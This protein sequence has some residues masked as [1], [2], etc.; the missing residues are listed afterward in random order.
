MLDYLL[1]YRD[2]HPGFTFWLRQRDRGDRL[3]NGYWFQGTE[4]YIFL[5]FWARSGGTNMTRSIGFVIYL[6]GNREFSTGIEVVFNGE[7]D[8]E[9]I[10]L[11]REIIRRYQLDRLHDTKY[12]KLLSESDVFKSLK[13]F[14]NEIKPAIDSMIQQADLQEMFISEEEFTEMLN[15]TLSVREAVPKLTPEGKLG[16]VM[17]NITW[18]S[19]DWQ[20]PSTDKSSHGWVR[21]GN[22]P[23]ES[24]NFDFDN[25]RNPP[26][27]V[28]GFAQFVAAP[29]I[30]GTNNII[31]FY[32]QAKIVGFYGKAELLRQPV[33]LSNNFNYNLVGEKSLSLVLENKLE[34]IKE[35]GYLE[36]KQRMGQ[37]GFIYLSKPETVL[38]ILREAIELNPQQSEKLTNLQNWIEGIPTSTPEPT[39]PL[40]SRIDTALNQIFFGPPGTGK[41]YS[42]VEEAVSI[43]DPQFYQRNQSDRNH[44]KQRFNELLITD[45]QKNK[46]QI[47][48]CTFHQSFSYE[49]FVEGIKPVSPKEDDTYLK[50]RIEDGI[51]KKLCRLSEDNSTSVRVKTERVVSWSEEKFKQA[52]FYKISLGN[53]NKEDDQAIYEYCVKHNCIALGYGGENDFSGLNEK[54]IIAR[55]RELGKESFFEQVVNRF[56]HYLKPGNYVLVSNGN[57][58]VRA[59]GRVTGAYQYN[60]N[61]S[62]PYRHF[63]PVEW[64]LVDQDIP[65]AEV[66]DRSLSQQTLYKLDEDGIRKDFFVSNSPKPGPEAARKKNFVLII[67][68]INRGNISSIFGELITLIE[69][70]KRAGEPEESAATLPYSKETLKVP[71]NVYLIGT[72]NTADRSIE[73]LDTALRR[74]FSFRE[75][76]SIPELIR[77]EGAS[78]GTIGPID[79][80]QMLST[81][82]QR[83]EKLIDKDH[84][85]GH[86]YFMEDKT[87]KDLKTTFHNKVI[88]LLQEYFF[89]DFGKIGLVLGDSFVERL[90]SNDFKF[91]DFKGYDN[92]E[93]VA[94]DLRAR[95]VYQIKDPSQWDFISIYE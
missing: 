15:K 7:T 5:S 8:E 23:H 55:C 91:A 20:S 21:D 47:A 24:W 1:R 9:I 41:T 48:F 56:I 53:S 14:L 95:A 17:V 11:Y 42:T 66:Y 75:M 32:S 94:D 34:N 60:P 43:V 80:V 22:I 54:Q 81:I 89:G 62:I 6:D 30:K 61:T 74:R 45:W 88:P 76:P 70:D 72:M 59:L 18:N 86:A 52:V 79:L 71:N 65:I 73:A 82:N 33:T 69:K 51:F 90:N 31:I 85:I 39:E 87:E 27:K 83:I 58:Y 35:R 38:K 2:Q 84:K 16:I 26:D 64:L 25:E 28:Y 29:L 49:D 4:N 44:L 46:G 3:S 67:D 37:N 68:E 10:G 92:E 13:H 78:K 57:R 63:R 40:I 93:N 36:E 19:N 77:T 12:R 50:Y